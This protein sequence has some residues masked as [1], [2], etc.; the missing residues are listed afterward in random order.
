[1]SIYS[2][3]ILV[4]SKFLFFIYFCKQRKA[5][6]NLVKNSDMIKSKSKIYRLCEWLKNLTSLT[7]TSF[8]KFKTLSKFYFFFFWQLWKS[9]FYAFRKYM[10]RYPF[11]KF[12]LLMKWKRNLRITVLLWKSFLKVQLFQPIVSHQT[13]NFCCLNHKQSNSW[14][15]KERKRSCKNPEIFEI[16]QIYKLFKNY[17]INM[18]KPQTIYFFQSYK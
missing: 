16:M 3:T 8:I 6:N 7:R 17:F 15:C 9:Y 10:S 12:K 18:L 2:N 5:K 4:L 13:D 14:I 1:M 11:L